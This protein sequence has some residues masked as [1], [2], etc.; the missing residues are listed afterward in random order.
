MGYFANFR[1][2]LGFLQLPRQLWKFLKCRIS[3]NA[4]DI[5]FT[6]S[7]KVQYTS[8]PSMGLYTVSQNLAQSKGVLSREIMSERCSLMLNVN[9][10]VSQESTFRLLLSVSLFTNYSRCTGS[11]AYLALCY[12]ACTCTTNHWLT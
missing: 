10:Q 7:D 3:A 2:C 12:C 11:E 5:L 9:A 4:C 6:G 1:K 8:M